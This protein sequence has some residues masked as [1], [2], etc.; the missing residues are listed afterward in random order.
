MDVIVFTGNWLKQ[1]WILQKIVGFNITVKI[2]LKNI[3]KQ[4]CRRI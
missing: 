2:N 3:K 1:H 4:T